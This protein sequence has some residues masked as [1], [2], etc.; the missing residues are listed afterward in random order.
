MPELRRSRAWRLVLA[1]RATMRAAVPASVRRFA[2][3]AR[4]RRLRS[5]L[6]WLIAVLVLVLA[7]VSA[8]L[9][10][11]TKVFGVTTVRV[12]GAD[13]TAVRLVADV[14]LGTPLARVDTAAVTRRV[15]SYAPVRKA[16][17]SR[18]WP[19]TL[20]VRVWP[21]TAVAVVAFVGSYGLLADD[22]VVFSQV[23]TVADGL[24]LVRAADDETTKDALRVLRALSPTIR[25][26]LLRL[27]ADAPARI[28]LEL[29]GGRVVV[30][31]DSTENAAKVRVATM[32]LAAPGG[33]KTFDVSAPSVVSVR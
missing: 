29:S 10:Y 25:S 2:R 23:S 27:V 32:L 17:V 21:R 31:G 12:I 4:R 11:G 18:S 1:R 6:P 33:A 15:E 22:G 13:P 9:V 8:G 7:G 14:R 3:R 24:P 19:R 26:A 5:A 28:R 20:V 16:T 30:W